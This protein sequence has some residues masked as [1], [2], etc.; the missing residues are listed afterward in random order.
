[1]TTAVLAGTC[2]WLLVSA[3]AR[4]RVR[5]VWTP[6]PPS[7]RRPTP[8]LLAGALAPVAG[9]LIVGWPWG[10]VA[11]LAAAPI[12]RELVRSMETSGSRRRAERI[13]RQLPAALDLIAAALAAG[14]P[15][16]TALTVVAEAVEQP[17]ASDLGAVAGRL[18]V[19]GDVR[20]ALVDVPNSL[21][22]LGRALRRAEESGAPVAAVV[23]AA[24]DDVRRDARAARREAARRVGVRTAAPLGLCFL[25]AFL[26]VGIVP[27]VIALARDVVLS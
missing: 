18:V 15:P 24:A 1:M 5:R 25:P 4:R 16:A 22:V 17:L 14:R 23:S 3:P 9:L 19:A 6:A 10:P 13:R 11:G 7:G 8:D 26:V 2:A 21:T 20:A 12:V 27:T